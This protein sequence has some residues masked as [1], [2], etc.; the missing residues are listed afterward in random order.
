MK[1]A[2]MTDDG[3]TI[4]VHF[5]R[6]GKCAVVEVEDGRIVGR[7]LRDM[8]AHAAGDHDHDHN[9]HGGHHR[10]QHHF[11]EKLTVMED[12][13]VV[14]CRGMGNPAYD[15]LVAAGLKPILTDSV[16]VETAVQAYI[17]GTI[18]DNPRRRHN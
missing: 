4:S 18:I 16:D 10:G 3:K 2:V 1:I 8:P 11:H 9:H 13:Q 14:L 7:E 12:C 15:K 5:G 6:A 17:D